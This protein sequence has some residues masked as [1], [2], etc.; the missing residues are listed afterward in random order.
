MKNNDLEWRKPVGVEHADTQQNQQVADYISAQNALNA[1]NARERYTNGTRLVG[2]LAIRLG[3]TASVFAV[4]S[5][6]FQPAELL[7]WSFLV[8]GLS[9]FIEIVFYMVLG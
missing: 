1:S 4:I 2:G 9:M 8:A 3:V 6:T 5:P 7:A